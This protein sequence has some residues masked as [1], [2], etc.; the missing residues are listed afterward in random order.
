MEFPGQRPVTPFNGAV[1]GII[2]HAEN[3]VVVFRLRA[4][5][6]DMGFLVEELDLRGGGVVLFGLIEGV[7]GGFKGFFIDVALGEGEEAV[8][9]VRV[10]FEGFGAIGDGLLLGIHLGMAVSRSERRQWRV[11]WNGSFTS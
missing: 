6:S 7:E 10:L 11:G 1:V 9:G 5:Q 2:S 4:L 3:F 8:E